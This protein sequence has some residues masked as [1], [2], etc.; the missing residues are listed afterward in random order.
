M[1]DTRQDPPYAA[2]EVTMLRSWLDYHRRT[3]RLKADGLDDEQLRTPL[4]P[5]DLTIG[6]LL[7]HL[8]YV[9][10]HWLGRRAAR[11]GAGGA[12][13]ER[14]LGRRP[15]LEMTSS[16]LDSADDLRAL[17]D[18]SI[19]ASDGILEEALATGDLDTLSRR[20]R[21]GNR[22][23]LRWILVHLIEEYAR[24]NGHADLIRQSIDGQTGE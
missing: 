18:R 2:D 20:D 6:A 17:L 14:G 24:H 15:R 16:R 4:P 1:T 9:E 10:D 12:V 5:S 3:L 11:G 7:K 8:A 22:A 21:E 13:G 23:S 19:A